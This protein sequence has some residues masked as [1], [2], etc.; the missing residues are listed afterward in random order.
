MLR[1]QRAQLV[2][3]AA[4]AVLS[5]GCNSDKATGPRGAGGCASS[6]TLTIGGSATGDLAT[7]PCKLSD[8]TFLR[9]YTITLSQA[10]PVDFEVDATNAAFNP[11]VILY[12]DA[13]TDTTAWIALADDDP[14]NVSSYDTR[15]HTVLS[16]GTY[17]VAVNYYT[18][19][20]YGK[21]TI[22]AASGTGSADFCSDPGSGGPA[23]W[24]TPGTTSNQELTTTDCPSPSV[25]GQYS[26][27]VG[28]YLKAGQ[29][30]TIRA[31]SLATDT[32]LELYDPAGN[33]IKSDDN[34]GGDINPR[35]AYTATQSG[36]YFIFVT[37]ASGVTGQ[38]SLSVASGL[39]GA[40]PAAGPAARPA[41]VGAATPSAPRW[42]EWMRAH[43]PG[44][45]KS[46]R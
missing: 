26:D 46:G 7:S 20:T 27:Y 3:G 18:G 4:L 22:R 34:S 33:F 31:N 29:P 28:M 9:Y 43:V 38:Y 10:A 2:L 24:V 45:A 41:A 6:G 37:A 8:G 30:V 1:R 40:P 23:L 14:A 17:V 21:Y 32:Q 36:Y 39:T 5:L 12:R 19:E 25:P 44:R 16:A 15:L 11:V 35:I 13:Y 42:G